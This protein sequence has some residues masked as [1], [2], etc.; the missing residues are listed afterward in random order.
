[1]TKLIFSLNFIEET[2]EIVVSGVGNIR[3]WTFIQQKNTFV[4]DSPRLC[5][6]DLNVDDWVTISVY[7]KCGQIYAAYD[8]NV[9]VKLI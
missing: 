7:V 5:I 8:N 1:M 3:I 9:S 2:E 4:L 6:S